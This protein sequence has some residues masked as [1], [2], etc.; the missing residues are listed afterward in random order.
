MGAG[1][2]YFATFANQF[3]LE[4]EDKTE[5]KHII[6]CFQKGA[7]IVYQS[8]MLDGSFWSWEKNWFLFLK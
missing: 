6:N 2:A 4:T 7:D 3:V 5:E 1:D 8:L